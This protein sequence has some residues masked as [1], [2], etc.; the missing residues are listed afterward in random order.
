MCLFLA[1]FG[2]K[3]IIAEYRHVALYTLTLKISLS[4]RL[5]LAMLLRASCEWCRDGRVMVNTERDSLIRLIKILNCKC[6]CA[7]HP[8]HP[9]LYKEY[10]VFSIEY[11]RLTN[12]VYLLFKTPQTLGLDSIVMCFYLRTIKRCIWCNSVGR[13]VKVTVNRYCYDYAHSNKSRPCP[14]YEEEMVTSWVVCTRLYCL[15]QHDEADDRRRERE[16]AA[17]E[18]QLEETRWR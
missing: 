5:L 6:I 7:L 15:E 12:C 2:T 1:V 3:I 8:H 16:R 11:F 4:S 17:R 10:P 18:R 9:L 14:R 13:D